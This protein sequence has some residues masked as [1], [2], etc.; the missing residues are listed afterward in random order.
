MALPAHSGT[1]LL[2]FG[3][4]LFS[5]IIFRVPFNGTNLDTTNM[6]QLTKDNSDHF[7]PSWS[8][9]GDT[10][11]YDS[12]IKNTSQPFQIYKMA[13]DGTGQ[14]NIGDM[15]INS[16]YS[17]EPFCT[18]GNQVLHIRGDK[19]ST[20]VFNMVYCG[21]IAYYL[22]GWVCSKEFERVVV[23]AVGEYLMAWYK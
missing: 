14:T 15:G 2:P 10:I 5:L 8:P 7:F 11:Y 4:L 19:L 6:I 16:V 23:E 3:F 1:A 21:T 22:E 9:L 20:H 18:P 13:A 17:R 12:D